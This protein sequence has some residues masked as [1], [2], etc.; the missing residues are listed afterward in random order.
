M[1]SLL[2][3]LVRYYFII[4]FLVLEIISLVLVVSYNNFHQVKF[5]SSSNYLT[6]SV[7]EIK[8]NYSDYFRLQ[9]INRD[10]AAE[11]TLLK[12]E[13][14]KRMLPT[15]QIREE[16][17]TITGQTFQFT[18]ADVINNSVNTQHNY[19]TL[20]KGS[21]HGVKPDM[22]IVCSKGLVGVITNVSP[23]FSTG[24]SLLNTRLSI[25][26]KFSRSESFGSLTWDGR[27]YRTA[28]LKEI[29]FHIPV[30][31]GD[32]IV[33]SS[34]SSIFPEGIMIGTVSEFTIE[35][36]NPFY[37]IHV[38]L[39][40]DFKMLNHVEVVQNLKKS[41]LIRLEKMNKYD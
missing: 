12:N 1:K 39:S 27:N 36:G 21:R 40:T 14:Q 23:Y 10:L 35:S 20:N 25:P 4:L 19:I 24:L 30:Q 41:E 18:T 3:F 9:K 37:T 26:A 2:G 13:L 29:P 8:S 28:I 22:G 5:L 6:A 15:F 7:F 17:D 32:T 34:Y 38:Q 33:T 11:N 31:V 16:L